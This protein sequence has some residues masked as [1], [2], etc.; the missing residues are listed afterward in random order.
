MKLKSL[1]TPAV[2]LLFALFAVGILSVLLGGARTYRGLTERDERSYEN[3]TAVQYLATRVRQAES[4]Q[5]VTL[6]PFGEGDGLCLLQ[7]I[8]GT[9][10][11]TRVYCYDGWLRELFARHDVTFS[12]Q[13]GEKVLP[14]SQLELSLEDGLLTATLH[15]TDGTSQPLVLHIGRGTP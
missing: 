3:R 6:A 5:D 1:I 9:V 7:E 15:H 12:P 11:A 8:D 10:Y 14:L 4:P 2:L 13:D